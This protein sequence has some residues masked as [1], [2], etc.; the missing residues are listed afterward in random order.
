MTQTVLII[1]DT[2]FQFNHQ[3]K[4]FCLLSKPCHVVT[5]SDATVTILYKF[6]TPLLCDF[7]GQ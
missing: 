1:S 5:I 4:V 7:L 3:N 6:F 2:V